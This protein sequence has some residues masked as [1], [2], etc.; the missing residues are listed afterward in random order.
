[1]EAGVLTLNRERLR[2]YLNQGRRQARVLL[3]YLSQP[4]DFLW[5]ILTGNILFSFS[6]LFALVVGF[7]SFAQ[8]Y[9]WLFLPGFFLVVLIYVSLFD[10][11][12][13]TLFQRFPNRL[14]MHSVGTFR[15]IS[16]VLRPLVWVVSHFGNL[17]LRPS[18]ESLFFDNF[19]ESREQIKNVLKDSSQLF[20]REEDSLISNVINLGDKHVS[21]WMR[22]IESSIRVAPNDP[23]HS[24]VEKCRQSGLNRLPVLT[25]HGTY[26]KAVGEVGLFPV[27]FEGME[28][29]ESPVENFMQ[30][31]LVFPSDFTVHQALANLQKSGRR[32]AIIV[33]RDHEALG[34]VTLNDV[35]GILFGEVDI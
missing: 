26:F 3:D 32:M 2:H 4:A 23:V 20:T 28:D 8:Q 7:T 19:Y 5:T 16:R 13:K 11:L 14:C 22:P 25:D 33:G 31:P 18:R 29:S 10:L 24:V 21:H 35:V 6:A 15:F 17:W 12:P 30:A 1:M 9:P 34:L 27:L